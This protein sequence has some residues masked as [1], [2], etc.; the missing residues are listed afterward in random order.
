MRPHFSSILLGAAALTF[1]GASLAQVPGYVIPLDVKYGPIDPGA[2]QRQFYDFAWQTFIALNWPSRHGGE[3]AEPDK[4]RKIGDRA[5]D[6]SLFPVVWLGYKDPDQLF[7]PKGAI[8]AAWNTPPPPPSCQQA[9]PGALFLHTLDKVD[10]SGLNQAGFYRRQKTNKERGPVIDQALKYVL[11]DQ[12]MNQS[13]YQYTVDNKYY[14]ADNQCTAVG[15]PNSKDFHTPP[16]GTEPWMQRLPEWARQGSIEI[17]AAWRLLDPVKDKDILGRYYHVPAFFVKPHEPG[18][19]GQ[20]ENAEAAL[21]GFHILRLTPKTGKTWFWATFEQIDNVEVN[22]PERGLPKTPSF[23][24]GPKGT[25]PPPYPKGY[26]KEPAIIRGPPLPDPKAPV[27]VSRLTPIPSAVEE[28]NKRYRA[29]LKGTVWYFYELVDTMNQSVGN[30]KTKQMLAGHNRPT[31]KPNDVVY[32]NTFP[33][34]NTTMETYLQHM[35]CMDCHG[36]YGVPIGPKAKKDYVQFGNLQIFTFFL[37][38]A[39]FSDNPP[40]GCK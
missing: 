13:E 36:Y 11:Y 19:P 39:D 16:D 2:T 25:P 28:S 22:E 35:S 10:L 4:S 29:G 15:S 20:C 17:K 34:A 32:M 37:Q 30:A 12:R 40:A 27:N 21:V 14:L 9:A 8:P 31:V 24:P 23:N 1:A 26:D 7:L 38:H 6:G 3:R 5:P 33:M 18:K